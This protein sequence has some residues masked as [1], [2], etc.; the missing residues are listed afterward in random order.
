MMR[1]RADA[2]VA[3]R[4]LVLADGEEIAAEHRAVQHDPHDDRVHDEQR[5]S[6]CAERRRSGPVVSHSSVGKLAPKGKPAVASS[7]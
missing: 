6:G 7:V 2:A 3:R 1:E 4:L 5:R